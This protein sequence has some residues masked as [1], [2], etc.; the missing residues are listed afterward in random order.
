MIQVMLAG[1]KERDKLEFINR[2]SG[3]YRGLE[4]KL[5]VMIGEMDR[6]RVENG[7]LRAAL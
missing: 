5:E 4:G 2:L 7:E 3:E 6:L 1:E